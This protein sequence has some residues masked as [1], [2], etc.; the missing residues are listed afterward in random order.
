MGFFDFLFKKHTHNY[1][2][3]SQGE[4]DSPSILKK[5]AFKLKR[6]YNPEFVQEIDTMFEMLN[7]ENIYIYEF[8]HHSQNVLKA[9]HLILD[10]FELNSGN[11]SINDIQVKRHYFWSNLISAYFKLIKSTTKVHTQ[12]IKKSILGLIELNFFFYQ[13]EHTEKD[14]HYGFNYFDS[15]KHHSLVVSV[16]SK[17]NIDIELCVYY[18]SYALEQLSSITIKGKL[19]VLMH[20]YKDLDEKYFQDL[21]SEIINI[22]ANENYFSQEEGLYLFSSK[23]ELT[24]FLD[25]KRRLFGFNAGKSTESESKDTIIKKYQEILLSKFENK[26]GSFLLLELYCKLPVHKPEDKII[27][28]S[29]IAKTNIDYRI[30][31]AILSITLSFNAERNFNATYAIKSCNKY[32][33]EEPLDDLTYKKLKKMTFEVKTISQIKSIN[34]FLYSKKDSLYDIQRKEIFHLKHSGVFKQLYLGL[35]IEK[36]SQKS[37]IRN[38]IIDTLLLMSQVLPTM[39]IKEAQSKGYYKVKIG[40]GILDFSEENIIK[41]NQILFE[42]NIPYQ[43]VDLYFHKK[44]TSYYSVSYLTTIIINEEEYSYLLNDNNKDLEI[45]YIFGKPHFVSTIQ[46]VPPLNNNISSLKREIDKDISKN[47]FVHDFKWKEIKTSIIDH[48]PNKTVWYEIMHLIVSYSGSVSPSKSWAKKI[49]DKVKEL[50][51][52]EFE[53]G[54]DRLEYDVLNNDLWFNKTNIK[55]LRGMI[56]SFTLLNDDNACDKISSL[57]EKSYEKIVNEGP[58]SIS[59]GSSCMAA[60]VFIE[61]PESYISLKTLERETTYER[62]KNELNKYLIVFE[63]RAKSMISLLDETLVEDFQFSNGKKI[64]LVEPP[65]YMQWTINERKAQTQW[66]DGSGSKLSKAPKL[67]NIEYR[68]TNV[69]ITKSINKAIQDFDNKMKSYRFSEISYSLK[70]WKDNYLN[71]NFIKLLIDNFLWISIK[72]ERDPIVFITIDNKCLDIKN[73]E[74]IFEDSDIIKPYNRHDIS[75]KNNQNWIDYFIKNKI[76]PTFDFFYYGV[77]TIQEGEKLLEEIFTVTSSLPW[78]NWYSIINITYTAKARDLHFINK[79]ALV[80]LEEKGTSK[81]SFTYFNRPAEL[82]IYENYSLKDLKNEISPNEIPEKIR[83]EL[84]NEIISYSSDQYKRKIN[85][86]IEKLLVLPYYRLL[87][88]IFTILD[89]KRIFPNLSY[90]DF[91]ITIKGEINTYTIQILNEN[92]ILINSRNSNKSFYYYK[93]VIPTKNYSILLEKPFVQNSKLNKIFFFIE[94]FSSD[95]SIRITDIK[96]WVNNENRYYD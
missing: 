14:P 65:Y 15:I 17:Y 74:I 7:K 39:V 60:L 57:L 63:R 34:N 72:D 43:I 49:Q 10:A 13:K 11:I 27:I 96:N 25:I 4:E 82:K 78:R 47:R 29:L 89:E 21:K 23:D 77:N 12:N 2:D 94:Q 37:E 8:T 55:A 85:D 1:T 28:N 16:L 26:K 62:F 92:R 70:H 20:I 81:L 40:K 46:A 93:D 31:Q 51:P 73:E 86:E 66:I 87:N 41:F 79:T 18:I 84:Y 52:E 56:W 24:L 6:I 76:I 54:M 42:E 45:N 83:I 75:Q 58:R 38:I 50:S 69:N 30:L 33:K 71:H 32:F 67:R 3:Q 90:K 95:K 91:E 88:E 64:L 48:F 5:K 59:G 80:K 19:F 68:K 22:A 44:I 35:D 53:L 36:Y 9:K 61:T